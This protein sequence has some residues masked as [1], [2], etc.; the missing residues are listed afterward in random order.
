MNRSATT[1]IN[2]TIEIHQGNIDLMVEHINDDTQWFLTNGLQITG[3]DSSLR[4]FESSFTWSERF[5][6]RDKLLPT[7]LLDN[8]PWP[9]I[10]KYTRKTQTIDEIIQ[11][12]WKSEVPL[13]QFKSRLGLSI[14]EDN[15]VVQFGCF[16]IVYGPN[17][18]YIT[19][20]AYEAF[21]AWS[22]IQHTLYGFDIFYKVSI[23]SED[24]TKDKVIVRKDLTKGISYI[25]EGKFSKE[26]FQENIDAEMVSRLSKDVSSSD[27]LNKDTLNTTEGPT[28]I[29]TNPRRYM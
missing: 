6:I 12:D 23:R 18:S 26:T 15:V 25:T 9:S 29:D 22:V 13:F 20:S 24:K 11:N 10:N 2:E 7:E 27:Q 19:L 28:T 16:Y 5:F 14:P 3:I 17:I 4:Q 8:R 21:Y 1:N